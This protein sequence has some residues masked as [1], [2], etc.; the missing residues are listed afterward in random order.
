MKG[1]GSWGLLFSILL[2]LVLGRTPISYSQAITGDILGTVKD[3]SGAVIPGAQVTLTATATGV[4]TKATTDPSGSY[5]FAQLKPG[6]YSLTA[7]KQGFQT[8]T[9]SDI[10]LLVGQRP[11]VDITLKVGQ[12]TQKVTVSAGGVQLLEPHTSSTGQVIQ[13]QAVEQLPLNGRNF[14]QLVTLGAGVAPIGTGNSPASFWTGRGSDQVT[15]S[16]AGLRESN[17]SF[18]VNGIE[19][20]NSR[21]GSVGFSPSVGA[22]QEFKD[23]TSN[24]SAETGRSSSVINLTYK[25]GAN[26]LHGEAYEFLRNSALDANDFFLNEAGTPI[27]SFQQ[28]DFGGNIGGAVKIPHIY[29]GHDRSF[30]FLNVEFLR[31][32]RGLSSGT[33][34]LPSR[35]QLAGNLA[36][37]SSGTGI[38]PTASPF[39]Q[40][41]PASVKCKNVINPFTGQPFPGNVI[42]SGMLN[43]VSQKWLQFYPAPNVAVTP[44]QAA[45]PSFNFVTTPKELNNFNQGISRVDHTLTQKDH[46][47]GSYSYY[48]QPHFLPGTLPLQGTNY[49]FNDDLITL[50]ETHIFTPNIV[51]EARFGWNKSRTFLVSEG[52]LGPNYAQSVFGFTNTSGNPFDF[53]VPDA[54]IQGF[55]GP[56]SFAESIGAVDQ[57][58][59]W[60]DNLSIVHGNHNLKLGINYIHQKFFQI[61]DF[62][63]IPSF[64]F[65]GR[66]TGAGLGDFLLGIPYSGTT[67][68]GDSS[69]ELR[70]NDYAG[71]I[72]DNWRVR[73]N[74]TLNLGVRYEYDQT[75][76]DTSSK[77][78]WFDPAVGTPVI[79]RSGGVR[80]GIVDP[81]WNNVAPRV[82]FAYSPGFLRDTVFRGAYGVFYATDNF[83]ELQF[84]VIGPDFYGSQ[85]V[86]SDPTT[87]TLQ[88]QNLFP[89]ATL[90]GGTANPFSIDKRNRTPYVQEWNFDVQ[91]TFQSNLLLDVGYIGNV[92]QKLWQRRN[93]N[94]ATLDPTGT[95]PIGQREPFPNYSWIL[96]TYGGGWSSYNGLA[97]RVEKRIS[98]GV[99]LLG[100]YTWSHAIDLGNTDDFSMISRDFK[101]YDKGNGDYDVRHRAVISYIW[102]LPIGRGRHFLSG[103][104]G[105]ANSLLGN[106]QLNGITTFSTGQFHTVSLGYDYLNIG[107]F[108]TSVPNKIGPTFAPNRSINNWIPASS[109]ALPGCP[110]IQPC[111]TATHIEGNAGR[112]GIPMPGINNFDFSIFKTFKITESLSSEFRAEFFNGFNHTQFGNPDLSLSDSTFGTISSLMHTPREIQFALKLMF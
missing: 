101:L 23:Q 28:N 77:T 27:P 45:T 74:F 81:D 67:S 18:L 11:E 17:M 83:N 82:G 66:F 91:H 62:A 63:G 80:N 70:A 98:H 22:V 72:E 69:Q 46:L 86:Y 8:T 108:S 47:S 33:A 31:S 30:F 2:G 9:I 5:L 1:I 14:M 102:E 15:A 21:F 110:T 89:S 43:P 39:C 73:P 40:A 76:Y 93:Q 34:L 24:F 79:S 36:D 4:S 12:V 44:G 57:Y 109:F 38:Y 99:Y 20:R 58:F 51:N 103:N 26:H 84:L 16:A 100:S 52:A 60:V 32:L 95:I 71:F 61:T 25:S 29:D 64:T 75:P 65:D 107:A 3:P 48:G 111:A 106:W 87:P 94:I 42:P 49:P 6:H 88:L 37:D 35:A 13:E 104:S 78:Q 105:I 41:N 50:D 10:N 59:D 90:G 54:G 55:T 97:V 112:N 92:G 19:V 68:V 53:G 7:S 56:G 85:T 96:L